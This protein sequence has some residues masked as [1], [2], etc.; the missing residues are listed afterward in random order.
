M[1]CLQRFY[2]LI[3]VCAAS[4]QERSMKGRPVV[5]TP[6]SS[7][8]RSAFSRGRC[9]GVGCGL[10]TCLGLIGLKLWLMAA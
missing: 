5:E 10:R 8:T 6:F 4:K 2:L 9:E 3:I 1:Q 7:S